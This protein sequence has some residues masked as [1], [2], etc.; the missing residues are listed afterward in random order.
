MGKKNGLKI[1]YSDSCNII[2]EEHYENDVKQKNTTY[3]YDVKGY[4]VWKKTN[5]IDNV[6]EGSFVK[7]FSVHCVFGREKIRQN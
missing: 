5:F 1:S 6:K 2:L 7:I 3:Y 4:K